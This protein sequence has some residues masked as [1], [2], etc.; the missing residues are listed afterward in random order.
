MQSLSSVS[1]RTD[2]PAPHFHPGDI[3]WWSRD[4]VEAG[5]TLVDRARLWFAGAADASDLVAWAW[6]NLPGDV[7]M[8]IHPDH[9]TPELVSA[10]VE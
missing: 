10:I 3:D 9:R 4:A 7:D 8:Q 5:S 2:W 1:W 6:F